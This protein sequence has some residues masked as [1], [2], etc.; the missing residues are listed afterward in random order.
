MQE[1]ENLPQPLF[2]LFAFC[3][4]FSAIFGN[5][6]VFRPKFDKNESV[7][8]LCVNKRNYAKLCVIEGMGCPWIISD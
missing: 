8:L 3:K 4:S 2:S 1:L 7:N 5:F 6:L